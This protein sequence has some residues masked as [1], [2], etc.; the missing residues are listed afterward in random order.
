MMHTQW[1]GI[2]ALA[3]L[4]GCNSCLPAQ[5]ARS[6][7]DTTSNPATMNSS[8]PKFYVH[9]LYSEHGEDRRSAIAWLCAQPAESRPELHQLLQPVENDLEAEAAI[10]ALGCIG[11]AGDV[12]LLDTVLGSGRLSFRTGMALAQNP[13]PAALAA[14]IARSDDPR[15]PVARGAIAGLGERGDPTVRPKLESLLQHTNPNIRWAAI[16]AIADLGFQ[17]SEA[18]LRQALKSESN[19]DNRSKIKEILD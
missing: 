19:R 14:L 18:I 17:P 8:D 13:S 4:M 11:D 5:D 9:Q 1:L 3:C 6:S 10:E 12:A 2:F 16:L 15:E 7:A